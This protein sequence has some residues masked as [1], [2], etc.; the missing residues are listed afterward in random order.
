MEGQWDGKPP[1]PEKYLE[2]GYYQRAL[3]HAAR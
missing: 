2:L 1:E 3:A